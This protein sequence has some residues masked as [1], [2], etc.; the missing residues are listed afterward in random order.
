MK[1]IIL[2]T[3]IAGA[4][5]TAANAADTV[6]KKITLT[7][8][9]N[10]SLFVSKPDGSTW[11]AS[12]ELDA[13]D[14]TQQ[15]FSKK[16]PVRVWSKAD[17]F[18]VRL[19]QPLTMTNAGQAMVNAKAVWAQSTGATELSTATDLTVTQ[20]TAGPNGTDFDGVYDLTI[21]ADA[22]ANA[23]NGVYSG[24]LV[25]LFEPGTTTP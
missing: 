16:L 17:T 9:I 20:V 24:D 15:S 7:A 22:P 23:A 5:V 2:A 11:Y 19:A 4:Y 3:L 14:Y 1:K 25:M 12:E 8:Q 13:R 10:D 18:N 21:T 6:S